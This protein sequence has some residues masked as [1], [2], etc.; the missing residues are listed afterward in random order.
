MTGKDSVF[1]VRGKSFI[2]LPLGKG[3]NLALKRKNKVL[4]AGSV[5]EPEIWFCTANEEWCL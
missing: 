3:W 2:I 1:T 5:Q 4:L